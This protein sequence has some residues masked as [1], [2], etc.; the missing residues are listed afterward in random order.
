MT[1]NSLELLKTQTESLLTIYEKYSPIEAAKKDNPEKL[2]DCIAEMARF[3]ILSYHRLQMI[4]LLLQKIFLFLQ[5]R[6]IFAR[7]ECT[8]LNFIIQKIFLVTG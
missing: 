4:L 3:I 6:M 7:P 2:K 5:Y 1:E 8:K